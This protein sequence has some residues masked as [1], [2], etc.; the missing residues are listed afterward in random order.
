MEQHPI[1]QQITSYEFKLV[2]EMTLKQFLKAAGGIVIML[3]IN[4]SKMVFFIKW[5][6]M[7]LFGAGGLAMAFLPYQDRPLE[8]WILAFIKSIYSPTIYTYKKRAKANWL[9]IDRTKKLDSEDDEDREPVPIKN[10]DKVKEFIQ[11]LPSV[12]REQEDEGV[13]INDNL[14]TIVDNLQSSVKIQNPASETQK[15]KS[16]QS[17]IAVNTS[18]PAIDGDDWREKSANLNL[19]TERLEATGKAVFGS[20]PMPDIPDQPNLIVGMVTDNQGKI[21]DGAIIEIQDEN[22]NPSRV[23]KSN[24]L[25]QFRISTPLASG[26]YL[27]ITEKENYKFDRVTIELNGEIVKPI[28]IIS[29]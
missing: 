5:P 3:L 22:G 21:L 24:A 17:Q 26:K 2:G 10:E 4:S 13:I 9:E 7:L 28:R 27:I 19:K 1:P 16:D 11:S 8:T 18:E 23:I 6:L 14:N 25:G 15:N 20:I 29:S 12:K